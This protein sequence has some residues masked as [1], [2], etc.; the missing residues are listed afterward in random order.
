MLTPILI[1][2]LCD[3]SYVNTSRHRSLDLARL[4]P[5]CPQMRELTVGDSLISYKPELTRDSVTF[6]ALRSLALKD[7]S[8]EGDQGCWKRMVSCPKNVA[9]RFS[10]L[11]R[12]RGR[13][14]SED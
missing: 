4:D 1:S 8:M 11:N 9:F 6:P 10:Q 5:L 2:F 13:A 3:P 7:I 14:I 12:S